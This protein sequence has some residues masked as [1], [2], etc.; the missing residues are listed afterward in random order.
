MKT[1]TLKVTRKDGQ[2][3]EANVLDPENLME[4]V[5]L[6]GEDRPFKLAR[7]EYIAKQKKKLISGRSRRLS[8]RIE[9]LSPEQTEALRKAGLLRK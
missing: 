2:E 6:Y 7:D 3:F 4:V 8:L 9:D 1:L 5:K